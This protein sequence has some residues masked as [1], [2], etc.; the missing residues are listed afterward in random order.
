M[1]IAGLGILGRFGR[2]PDT[3]IAEVNNS[4]NEPKCTIPN[5]YII[6]KA[7]L[8]DKVLSRKLRRADKFTKMAVLAAYDSINDP[9]T[10]CNLSEMDLA[11]TG[12]ILTTAFGPHNTTFSFLDDIIEYGE[13]N[14]SAIK[15]SHSVHNAAASYIALLLNITGPTVTITQFKSPVHHAFNLA[16]CWLKDNVCDTVL[17][18]C[19]DERGE[20]FDIAAKYKLNISK[21]G[22]INPMEFSNNA[23]AIPS[24]G[25]VCFLLQKENKSKTPY[26]EISEISFKNAN[27]P[28]IDLYI[29][30]ADGIPSDE[31]YYA[32]LSSR[33][34]PLKA[35]TNI[36]GSMLIG[37]A[38]DCA[39]AALQLKNMNIISPEFSDISKIACCKLEC[40][41]DISSIILES[42]K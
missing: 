26:C 27:D 3:L 28:D 14:V 34:K 4:V 15:F 33:N 19:V 6:D 32:D 18:C 10:N 8:K 9:N 2:G 13:D 30:G 25:S 39:V 31:S 40:N 5:D 42:M 29:I 37:T 22:S 7:M 11:K 35:Y 41:K 1:Y 38:F 16:E 23:T 24:E 21:T 17:V 20:V 12:L 36:Y